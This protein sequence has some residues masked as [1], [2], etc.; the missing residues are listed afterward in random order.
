LL[1]LVVSDPWHAGEFE[2]GNGWYRLSGIL[3][4]YTVD[5]KPAIYSKIIVT[6]ARFGNIIVPDIEVQA[7]RE[8]LQ[9]SDVVGIIS[10]C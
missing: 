3:A 5:G 2:Q 8:D 7:P 9:Q 1:F 4:G 6:D 10:Q